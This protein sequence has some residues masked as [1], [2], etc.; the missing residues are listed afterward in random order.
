MDVSMVIHLN[1][2]VK[3]AMGV[4]YPHNLSGILTQNEHNCNDTKK[5]LFPAF[6]LNLRLYKIQWGIYIQGA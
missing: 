4:T 3:D 1:K 2:N 5:K 6:L